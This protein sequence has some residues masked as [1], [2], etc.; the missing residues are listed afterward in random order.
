MNQELNIFNNYT[1]FY[2]SKGWY[3]DGDPSV[4]ANGKWRKLE[5]VNLSTEPMRYDSATKELEVAYHMVINVTYDQGPSGDGWIYDELEI[6]TKW[7]EIFRTLVINYDDLGIIEVPTFSSD[8]LYII[9]C[10]SVYLQYCN[11]YANWIELFH[12]YSTY[13]EF[14]DGG[15][16]DYLHERI[17]TLNKQA[18]G[19]GLNLDYVLLVGVPSPHLDLPVIPWWEDESAYCDQYLACV[20]DDP[21]YWQDLAIGRMCTDGWTSEVRLQRLQRQFTKNQIYNMTNIYGW[22][23]RSLLVA[24]YPDPDDYVGVIEK[25]AEYDYSWIQPDFHLLKGTPEYSGIGNDDI[26]SDINNGAATVLYSGH[27]TTT[28]WHHWTRKQ[29]ACFPNDPPPPQYYSWT[30]QEIRDLNNSPIFPVVFNIACENAKWYGSQYDHESLVE[31]WVFDPDG[32]VAAVGSSG[33]YF[34]GK[35]DTIGFNALRGI[36]DFENGPNKGLGAIIQWSLN[37]MISEFGV[38]NDRASHDFRCTTL[39]GDPAM[40]VKVSQPTAIVE[41]SKNNEKYVSSI[42]SAY[43]YSLATT[44]P[45]PVTDYSTINFSLAEEGHVI[46]KLFDISGRLV[47]VLIDD[48]LKAGE[49]QTTISASELTSGVYITSMESRKFS[50]KKNIVV[51]K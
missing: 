20:H 19:Y 42:V 23:G 21:D 44:C 11:E 29:S 39:F 25:M 8:I 15:D 28:S 22:Q 37:K 1:E 14:Y 35:C 10:R 33:L 43:C 5:V 36:Y 32:A 40:I 13:V 50:S 27:G 6:N 31:E 16:A 17:K 47:D 41:S 2:K 30:H 24:H 3:P 49:Y 46:I 7:A 12:G 34:F 51:I 48:F 18:E 38:D 45:N 26:S 4:S 9:L